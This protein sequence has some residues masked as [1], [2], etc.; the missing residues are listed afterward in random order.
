M[1]GESIKNG[2]FNPSKT[3][4]HIHSGSLGN[5]CTKE[6]K[7]KFIKISLNFNKDRILIA[8]KALLNQ[9]V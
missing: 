8:E 1:I 3:V 4:K 2:T 6:I 7:E 9:S 5:L